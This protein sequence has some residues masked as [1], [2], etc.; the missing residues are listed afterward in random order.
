MILAMRYHSEDLTPKGPLQKRGSICLPDGAPGG[1]TEADNFLMPV[2]GHAATQH[3]SIL[4][5]KCGEQGA[6]AFAFVV[7]LAW[8]AAGGIG[9]PE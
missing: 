9:V 6:V 5:I 4:H 7:M 2:L 1:V 8:T 3:G